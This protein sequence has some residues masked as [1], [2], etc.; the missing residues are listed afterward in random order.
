MIEKKKYEVLRTV[1]DAGGL[2]AS[3]FAVAH[4]GDK[5]KK[6]EAGKVLGNLA[7]E[8]L[9]RSPYDDGRF[10]V[11][12]LGLEKIAEYEANPPEEGKPASGAKKKR[13]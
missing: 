1:R 5:S 11:S 8:N 9:V 13:K 2:T 7:E 10:V 6:K 3:E 4:Y 12:N